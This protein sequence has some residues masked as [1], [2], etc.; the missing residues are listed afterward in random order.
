M[1]TKFIIIGLSM[2][3]NQKRNYSRKFT[4]CGL[5]TSLIIQVKE[6]AEGEASPSKWHQHLTG[7]QQQQSATQ[8]EQDAQKVHRGERSPARGAHHHHVQVRQCWEDS[9]SLKDFSKRSR[10]KT[11]PRRT[12]RLSSTQLVWNQVKIIFWKKFENLICFFV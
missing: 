9:Q 12:F 6:G 3:W 5:I 10:I 7:A 4:A 1:F 2:F 8:Y 11:N